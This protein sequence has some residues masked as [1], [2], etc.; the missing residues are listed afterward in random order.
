MTY[1]QATHFAETWGLVFAVLLF[2]AAVAYALWPSNRKTFD[3]AAHAPL[4]KDD[5]DVRAR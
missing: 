2:A 5:D 4:A 3:E 1:A